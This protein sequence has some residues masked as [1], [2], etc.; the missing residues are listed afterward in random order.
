MAKAAKAAGIEP[1]TTDL[2]LDGDRE[3]LLEQL[4][5][6]RE[7]AARD[8]ETAAQGEISEEDALFGTPRP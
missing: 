1:P 7:Q 6:E 8:A 4:R 3:M 2:R 5:A